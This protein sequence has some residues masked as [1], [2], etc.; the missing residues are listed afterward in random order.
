MV[1]W[2]SQKIK[3]DEA[4]KHI[5]QGIKIVNELGLKPFEMVGYLY[6]GELFADANEREK[7]LEI[8]KGAEM[9]FHEMKMDYWLTRTE[10]ILGRLREGRIKE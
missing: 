3:I 8:L 4:E 10:G 5:R 1:G 2:K 9:A 7:A 6:L